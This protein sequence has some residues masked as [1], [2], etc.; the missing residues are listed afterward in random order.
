[1]AVTLSTWRKGWQRWAFLLIV[2]IFAYTT[3]ANV[4]ERPEGVKIASFFIVAI[5]VSSF[6]SRIFRT[7]ELRVDK[8][9]LD[10]TAQ[11]FL[12]EASRGTIRIL[13]NRPDQRDVHEYEVEGKLK[14]A[15]HH[16]PPDEPI[17]VFEVDV[18]DASDFASA[19]RVTGVNVDGH[20]VLR[21]RSPAVPNA[22]AAFLLYVRDQTG[23][24]P[25]VYFDWSEGNPLVHLLRY[26]LL[27]EGDTAPVTREVLRR[28]E[29]DPDRRPAVHVG[30]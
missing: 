1:V 17:L 29:P 19:L 6:V 30:G 27:G 3:I 11:A 23:K 4:I 22:I 10:G 15:H 9:E 7:T 20:R 5:I 16:I 12:A 24:I 14:R 21:T 18:G 8:V 25:H 26:L 2:L 13:A 28:A